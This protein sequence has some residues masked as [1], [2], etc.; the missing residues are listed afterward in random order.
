MQSHSWKVRGPVRRR[1]RVG[2]GWYE[3]GRT[4]TGNKAPRYGRSS[5]V[6]KMFCCSIGQKMET[7]SVWVEYSLQT[8]FVW[9]ECF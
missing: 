2:W 9:P 6:H 4:I 3:A 1:Q 5:E 8:C 7:H